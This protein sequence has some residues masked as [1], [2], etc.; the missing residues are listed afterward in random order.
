M[1]D[2][3][4]TPER[5]RLTAY[6][7]LVPLPFCALPFVQFL[8]TNRLHIVDEGRILTYALATWVLVLALGV[9]V[10]RTARR[11]DA[12]RTALV[13]TAVV[14]TFS[15]YSH[16]IPSSARPDGVA[17]NLLVWLVLAAGAAYG[18]HAASRHDGFRTAVLIAGCALVAIAGV[19]YLLHRPTLNGAPVASIDLSSVTTF[20]ETPNIYYFVLDEYARD[21]QLLAL[22]GFDNSAFR[23][24]LRDRGFIVSERARSSYNFTE[25][26]L[27][28]T[29][30]M[31]P[32]ATEPDDVAAGVRHLQELITGRP[33]VV[34]Q[35]RAAGYQYVFSPAGTVG[36][37][38]C[39][40][41]V[42]D[43]CIAPDE[44]GLT[45]GEAELSLLATTPLDELDLLRPAYTDPVYVVEEL[46][47]LEGLDGPTF[48]FAHVLMPHTPYR[49]D[50]DCSPRSPSMEPDGARYAEQV[51]CTNL[52]VLEAIDRIV[53]QDP[54][55]LIVLQSDHGGPLT[56]PAWTKRLD[57]W[58]DV[59]LVDR[60][61]VQSAIRLPERC[62]DLVPDDLA[63][64][65]TFRIVFGC[66]ADE[67]PTLLDYEAWYWTSAHLSELEPIPA[68]RL[69]GLD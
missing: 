7:L 5:R 62:A 44:S 11:A 32:T 21:D 14:V 46:G 30:S 43:R 25:L 38:I 42:A 55:A 23:S 64:V 1:D 37:S 52:L 40:L 41:E 24:E 51:R 15:S 69:A 2:L 31:E 59:D 3:A 35:L 65:N 28:S 49:Y 63:I 13:L 39:S 18:V 26:S 57:E 20:I 10:L 17:L 60:L 27:S 4:T 47:Q 54:T 6:A 29:L 16:I 56:R 8:N 67:V 68:E 61:A 19:D 53:A 66:L 33:P 34:E 58:S 45:L 36:W 22:T 12:E 50:A 48:L 9:I